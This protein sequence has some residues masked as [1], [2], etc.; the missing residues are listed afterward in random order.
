M[1]LATLFRNEMLKM[2]KRLSFWVTF[3]LFSF[4]VV[5]QFGEQL[6]GARKNPDDSFALPA[7]WENV[8]GEGA[9][10]AIIFGCVLLV[11]LIANEFSW[12]TARQNVIDGLSKEQWFA[13]KMMLMPILALLLLGELFL[14]GGGLAFLGTDLSTA[15]GPLMTG[16]QWAA[17]GGHFLAFLGVGSMAFVA[18]LAI[19]STG[20]A[21]AVWF[22]YIGF[23]EQLL[24][25]ILGRLGEWLRPALRFLPFHVFTSLTEY[26]QYDPVAYRRA[27]EA[28][29]ANDGRPPEIPATGEM[30][31]A[32][33]LWMAALILL[34]FL[35]FRKRDL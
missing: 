16:A 34:S 28:A 8:L 1:R 33:L 24:G 15:S 11:L 7:A 27:V 22:F 2:F 25:G 18:A 30:I 29:A 17:I 21:M 26:L 12:R 14:V 4:I 19:R 32:A 13:G 9:I 5:V 23:G 31:L 3:G 10:I 6:Y 20:P 35:W